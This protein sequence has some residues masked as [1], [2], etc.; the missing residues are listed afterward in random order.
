MLAIVINVHICMDTL[1]FVC[2]CAENSSGPDVVGLLTPSAA[3]SKK[4]HVSST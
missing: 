4:K 2:N 3:V 1:L